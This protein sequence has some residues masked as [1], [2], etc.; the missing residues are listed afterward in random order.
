MRVLRDV[1]DLPEFRNGVLTI[2][3]FDGVHLGHQQIIQRINSAAR[4][5]GGESILLTFH[6]HPRLVINP[7]DTSL[8]LLNTLDEKIALLERY[9]VQNL[10]VAPFSKE[11]SQYTAQQYVED[12]LLGKVKPKHIVIGYDHKFGHD[13][14]GDLHLLT[15]LARPHGVTVEEISKQTVDDIAVSST[16]ARKALQAGE[17]DKA[18]SLLGHAY[19]VTGKVVPG[20]R[21]GR[22]I[23]YPTAN[24]EVGNLNKL[25][26]PIGVYAVKVALGNENFAGMLSIGTNPT[27]DGKH[28]TIEVHIFDFNRDIYGKDIVVEF[29]QYLREEQKFDSVDA[30]VEQ[31]REDERISRKILI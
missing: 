29:V 6:P 10:I 26:P 8:K 20:L 5:I 31:M 21:N 28:E 22:A 7:N 1:N 30:L 11:F 9:G 3:T 14:Q 18:A 25:I 17:V 27:F 24:V 13:R 23:G 2:G 16:K 12:F 4:E 19:S 15:E